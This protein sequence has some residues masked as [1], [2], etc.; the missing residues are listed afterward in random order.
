VYLVYTA[1]GIGGPVVRLVRYREVAGTLG[2]AAVL[3]DDVPGASIHNGSRVRFGPD[4]HL[5]MT[6]GDMAAP[7]LA[8]DLASLNGKILRVAPDGTAP[9][10]NPYG[11][12]VWSWG[13]RNPQGID[14]HSTSGDLFATEHGASGNDEINVIDR[15]RNYGWP[16]I[17][18]NASRPGMETPIASFSPSVAPSGASFY[19]GSAF[20]AFRNDLFVATLRGQALLRVRLDPANPRRVLSIER[21]VEGRFGRLRDVVSGPDGYLYFVTNNRDGRGSA[22]AEDDRILRLVPLER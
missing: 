4:G 3:L 15:G 7:S 18:G 14:W 11:S 16:V 17:E 6:S 10:D 13:H 20:P 21:L 1:H 22:G 2:E 12:P 5:Y 19:R 9:R 8:Q